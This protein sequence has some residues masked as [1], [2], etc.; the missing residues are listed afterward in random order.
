M[1]FFFAGEKFFRAKYFDEFKALRKSGGRKSAKK[2]EQ[3]KS[4]EKAEEP[5]AKPL[6]KISRED[7]KQIQ[8]PNADKKP[9][10]RKRKYVKYLTS[11]EEQDGLEAALQEL[12]MEEQPK[13]LVELKA[14]EAKLKA[15]N[16]DLSARK[17][18]LSKTEKDHED[19]MQQIS[20]AA[21][22]QRGA[23]YDKAKVLDQ[24]I[25]SDQDKIVSLQNEIDEGNKVLKAKS[26]LDAQI[27]AF[28]ARGK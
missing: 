4:V 2:A 8:L 15:L 16:L 7:L 28:L 20:K 22:A 11:A 1:F 26:D 23:L 13:N 10:G 18:H 17:E 19:L 24:D 6:I 5:K 9:R 14:F 3:T 21:P 12:A 25:V 27:A